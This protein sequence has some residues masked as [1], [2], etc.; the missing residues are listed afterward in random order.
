MTDRALLKKY[1]AERA[2]LTGKRTTLDQR[3]EALD[4]V[5]GGLR[6][7]L[8]EAPALKPRSGAGK[9][10]G[11]KALILDVLADGKR[12]T[13][14]DI[15]STCKVEPTALAYHLKPLCEAGDVTRHGQGRATIYGVK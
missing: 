13:L 1:E 10:T 15:A 11:T 5:I 8:G 3:I 7:L 14:K 4:G 12:R 9:A 2:D 6:V